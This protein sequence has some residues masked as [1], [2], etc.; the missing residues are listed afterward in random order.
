ML[1]IQRNQPGWR[2]YFGDKVKEIAH[3][4]EVLHLYVVQA[5]RTAELSAYTDP[6]RTTP[7][8][9]RRNWGVPPFDT[10]P[11]WFLHAM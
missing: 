1:I 9:I 3:D 11:T 5:H 6:D 2:F 8:A 10:P 4:A 7:E